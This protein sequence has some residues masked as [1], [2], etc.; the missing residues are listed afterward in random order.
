MTIGEL[1]AESGLPHP[2]SA[3]GKIGVL[4]KPARVAVNAA[5]RPTLFNGWPCCG[6]H[7]P[8]FPARTKSG[9][10]ARLGPVSRRRAGG[11]NSPAE[12]NRNLMTRS[13]D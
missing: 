10:A 7:R 13:R 9:I 11:R 6:W 2:R 4:P 1:A 12:N 3:I 8:G 5:I